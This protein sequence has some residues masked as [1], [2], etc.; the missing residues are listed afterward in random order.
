MEGSGRV[1]GETVPAQTEQ[2]RIKH[3]CQVTQLSQNLH[4]GG[5]KWQ[6]TKENNDQKENLK[7][8]RPDHLFMM[9]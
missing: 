4:A 3:L 6:L 8:R 2:V 1:G 9:E 7:A 5:I